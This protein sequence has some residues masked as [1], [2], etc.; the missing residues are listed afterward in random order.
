MPAVS[1]KPGL[2]NSAPN[3]FLRPVLETFGYS[4][5]AGLGGD[6]SFVPVLLA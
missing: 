1:L 4:S 5:P 2:I 6:S 3:Q